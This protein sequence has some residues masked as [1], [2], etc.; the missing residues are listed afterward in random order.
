MSDLRAVA[1]HRAERVGSKGL[2]VAGGRW[3]DPSEAIDRGRA[4]DHRGVVGSRRVVGR[5]V[6]T[7]PVARSVGTSGRV[8]GRVATSGSVATS[9]RVVT[10]RRVAGRA[11][12]P[13][14]VP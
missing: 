5:E 12:G 7:R 6:A 13:R 10:S 9:G 14:G 8:A 1:G 2:V 3:V 11:A 4:A